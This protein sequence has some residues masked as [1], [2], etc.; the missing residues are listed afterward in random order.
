MWGDGRRTSIFQ[1]S[2]LESW[3]PWPHVWLRP[4]VVLFQKFTILPPFGQKK[5]RLSS[6][7]LLNTAFCWEITNNVLRSIAEVIHE[8]ITET[9][10]V[11]EASKSSDPPSPYR[12]YNCALLD[13]S[14]TNFCWSYLYTTSR[15]RDLLTRINSLWIGAQKFASETET[16]LAKWAQCEV[17]TLP[18]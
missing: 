18:T 4:V 6:V 13:G 9:G 7:S 12:E 11:E 3:S 1:L 15:L 17:D 10:I 5:F 2:V 14:S 8:Q 16:H